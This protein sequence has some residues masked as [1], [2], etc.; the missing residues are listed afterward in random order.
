MKIGIIGGGFTGLTAAYYLQKAGHDTHIFEG[1]PY[2]GGLAAG[3]KKTLPK[4]PDNWE[5]DLEQFYHHWFTND[6][7]VFELGD[8]IGVSEKFITQSPRTDVLYNDQMYA[9]DSPVALLRFPHLPLIDRFKTGITLAKL[10]YLYNEEKSA[11]FEHVTAAEYL[12]SRSSKLA[13]ERIWKPLLVGKFGEAYDQV[14]MRWFWARIYKRTPSLRYYEGGF[15]AF[16]TDIAQ[17]ITNLG[18]NIETSVRVEEVVRCDACS[19]FHIKREGIENTHDEKFDRV[20][21]TTPPQILQKLCLNLPDDYKDKLKTHDG[22][23]AFVLILR[24]HHQLMPQTYWLSINE[25]SWPFLA[26]V[27]HTNFMPKEKYGNENIV[28]IGDYVDKDHP[29]MQKSKEELIEEFTP[30]I[31][32]INP[33]F[34]TES[35][36]D[37]YLFKTN[38]AQPIPKLNHEENILPL[39]TPIEGLYLASMAQV[40]PWDRGTN[41]AIEMGKEVAGMINS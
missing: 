20:I 40:Y 21:V 8:A 7:F 27:E 36:I 41:Y 30:Y 28:Y 2:L 16:V 4:P 22:V 9:L 29:N 10:K 35:L 33:L 14:N 13:Y 17:A 24:L 19:G 34:S 6:N 11:M 12:Q 25:T 18:G 26:M 32:K 1:A 23:G 15:G 37:S 39:T 3:I 31:K 38:Y 5:W